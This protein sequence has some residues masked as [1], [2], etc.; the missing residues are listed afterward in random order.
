MP[1]NF[2][3]GVSDYKISGCDYIIAGTD[4]II[5][6]TDYIIAVADFRIN[7]GITIFLS[8]TKWKSEITNEYILP[9]DPFAARYERNNLGCH[10]AANKRACRNNRDGSNSRQR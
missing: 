6:V 10:E 2:I 1:I 3:I 7:E 9:D 8:L 4:F 5:T